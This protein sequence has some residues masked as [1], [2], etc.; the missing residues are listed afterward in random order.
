MPKEHERLSFGEG[1]GPLHEDAK[2]LPGEVHW[3]ESLVNGQWSS[4][5]LG[6]FSELWAERMALLQA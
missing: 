4:V 3:Q 2:S 6:P 1:E 5:S